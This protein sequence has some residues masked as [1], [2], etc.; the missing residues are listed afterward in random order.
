MES[1]IQ[2]VFVAEATLQQ[3]APPPTVTSQPVVM[4]VPTS[5]PVQVPE[6]TPSS[7]V[8]LMLTFCVW[9]LRQR[10]A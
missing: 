1:Q 5:V 2:Q 10:I 7:G 3:P 4:R 6:A 8:L 9:L